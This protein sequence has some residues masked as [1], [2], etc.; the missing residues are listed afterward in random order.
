MKRNVLAILVLLI[1]NTLQ[2]QTA[3][4]LFSSNDIKVSWLGIDFSHTKLIGAFDQI[5]GAFEQSPGSVK[6]EYF[7]AWNKL[8]INEP[9]KYD[10]NGMLR[11]DNVRYDID[12]LMKINAMTPLGDIEGYNAPDYGID[13]L[14]KFVSAY[15]LG[16]KTGLGVVFINECL[17]KGKEEA[18][19]HVIVLNLATKEILIHERVVGKPQGFGLRNYWAGSIYSVIKQVKNNYYGEWKAR[20]K[21][22]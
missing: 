2:A 6:N 19:F 11:K 13:D 14:K 9:K 17:N 12:M 8:I 18:I 20:Y 22:M 5:G 10:V 1:A 4:D 3:S 15:D 16:G 7:P 21:K